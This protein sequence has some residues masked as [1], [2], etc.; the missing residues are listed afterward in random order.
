MSQ[1][2]HFCRRYF[3]LALTLL[4]LL[5]AWPASVAF[6]DNG[7]GTVTDSATGLMGQVFLGAERQ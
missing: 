3:R 5:A 7:D 4:A 6:T 2:P 1:L